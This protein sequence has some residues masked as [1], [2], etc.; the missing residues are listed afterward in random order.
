MV[1]ALAYLS[2]LL[3]LLWYSSTRTNHIEATSC[4][5]INHLKY[6]YYSGTTNRIIYY[7]HGYGNSVTAWSWNRVTKR[8]ISDWDK[9]GVDRPNIVSL[10]YSSLWWHNAKKQIEVDNA[11]SWLENNVIKKEALSR[12]FY[13]DSMGAYNA[14]RFANNSKHQIDGLALIC[15]AIPRTI[16]NNPKTKLKGFIPLSY[17]ASR[18]IKDSLNDQ[19]WTIYSEKIKNENLKSYV[20]TTPVDQ[21]GFYLGGVHLSDYLKESTKKSSSIYEEQEVIHCQIDTK[22]LAQFLAN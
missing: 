10:S 7:F 4:S 1:N 9:Q 21:F 20:V 22:K 17:T 13:G 16:T 5:K 19:N 6:C 14:L 3:V 15:P 8:I 11:I 12:Y 18:V 2:S